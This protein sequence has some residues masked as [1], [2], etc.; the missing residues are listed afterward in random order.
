MEIIN[1]IAR[2]I[3]YKKRTYTLYNVRLFAKRNFSN[4]LQMKSE[5]VRTAHLIF[6]SS[7]TFSNRCINAFK[8]CVILTYID[9]V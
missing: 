6:E 3:K 8:L 9:I 7:F 5:K 4:S 2:K 1:Y